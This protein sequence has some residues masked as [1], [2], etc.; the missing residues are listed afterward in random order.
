MEEIEKV[1]EESLNIPLRASIILGIVSYL[2]INKKIDEDYYINAGELTKDII[3]EMIGYELSEDMTIY[4]ELYKEIKEKVKKI[5]EDIEEE[6]IEKIYFAI[7]EYFAK[8]YNSLPREKMIS[9]DE[10][11]KDS[12]IKAITRL[13]YRRDLKGIYIPSLNKRKYKEVVMVMD[14]FSSI[15]LNPIYFIDHIIYKLGLSERTEEVAKEICER[16]VKLGMH[17]GKMPEGIAAACVYI[18]SW[19][20]GE[21][22]T[23]REISKVTGVTE[24][25]I[26]NRYREILDI[27][28]W[29]DEEFKEKY[30][31]ELLSLAESYPISF[32]F[33]SYYFRGEMD[34]ERERD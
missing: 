16:F 24:P 32:G 1:F 12:L 14:G 22:R 13:V 23:Q 8:K 2:R 21:R 34:E 5:D 18:A 6:Y 7:I 30:R 20:T 17:S 9:M 31:S 4:G 26:R 10:E 19:I 25:T 15:H 11:E 3:D 29:L 33:I 27:L 28:L